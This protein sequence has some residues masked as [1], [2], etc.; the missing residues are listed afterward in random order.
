M[1]CF[2]L[3]DSFLV[4]RFWTL[5]LHNLSEPYLSLICE[6][7]IHR[8]DGW[9]PELSFPNRL[10][11]QILGVHD[12]G[13]Q[14][15]EL[16]KSRLIRTWNIMKEQEGGSFHQIGEAKQ[17]SKCHCHM[18][19]SGDDHR[20]LD[21][22]Y[23]SGLGPWTRVWTRPRKSGQITQPYRRPSL[24]A[25]ISCGPMADWDQR[26]GIQRREEKW[27]ADSADRNLFRDGLP[28]KIQLQSRR[29]TS[30]AVGAQTLKCRENRRALA[31]R[32][33]C[34]NKRKGSTK[35]VKGARSR[36]VFA[37]CIPRLE[38]RNP[39]LCRILRVGITSK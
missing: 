16:L 28:S 29:R 6:S 20:N 38:M 8:N 37:T 10:W 17:E 35:S 11:P 39:I 4:Q 25:L 7:L 32:Q 12:R 14:W 27:T 15:L 33:F 30:Y 2:V 18:K 9:F 13:V 36:D 19:W 1:Y 26:S 34:R 23:F 21:K 22:R 31:K 5:G 24:L 3:H